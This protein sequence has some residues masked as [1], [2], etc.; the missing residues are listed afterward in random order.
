MTISFNARQHPKISKARENSEFLTTAVSL[1]A[2]EIWDLNQDLQTKNGDSSLPK[3]GMNRQLCTVERDVSYLRDFR[4]TVKCYVAAHASSGCGSRYDISKRNNHDFIRTD[5]ESASIYCMVDEQRLIT[6]LVTVFTSHSIY[7]YTTSDV[8]R[9]KSDCTGSRMW[10]FSFLS[11]SCL[12]WSSIWLKSV[13]NLPLKSDWRE[14]YSPNWKT[15]EFY[16][17]LDLLRAA[18]CPLLDW[19]P[20]FHRIFLSKRLLELKEWIA[21]KETSRRSFGSLSCANR[22]VQ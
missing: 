8:K 12:R 1:C 22:R 3:G 7:I 14:T 11:V 10:L 15:P 13:H 16:F 20:P 5:S 19:R 9:K 21:L 17:F 4:V 2:P 18:L 6:V